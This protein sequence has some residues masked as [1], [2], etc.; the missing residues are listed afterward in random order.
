MCWSLVVTF[1]PIATSLWT[2]QPHMRESRKARFTCIYIALLGLHSFEGF[3][4][5]WLTPIIRI[6]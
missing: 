3:A 1:G 4:L 5:C 2:L 6:F